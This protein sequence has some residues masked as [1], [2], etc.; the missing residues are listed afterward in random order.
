[1]IVMNNWVQ[2]LAFDKEIILMS[3]NFDFKISVKDLNSIAWDLI[4]ELFL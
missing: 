3:R 4:D 2:K 1:M